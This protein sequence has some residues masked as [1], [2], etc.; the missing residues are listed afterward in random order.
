MRVICITGMPGAGKNE[1]AKFF[2]EKDIPIVHMGDVVRKEARRRRRRITPE[3]LGRISLELRKKFGE[4]E[5]ARRC[6]ER[7]GKMKGDALVIEGIRSL[8]EIAFFRKK[9][10][11]VYTT[12]VHSSQKTR[13]LRLKKRGR[14][15]DAKRWKEFEERDLR[16]LGYGMGSAIALADFLLINEGTLGELRE[17]VKRVYEMVMR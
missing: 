13:F 8:E 3:N 10:R 1:V 6:F 12:A 17:K 9:L 4:E 15:D 7:I 2:E 16:E 5:I 11:N 14:G